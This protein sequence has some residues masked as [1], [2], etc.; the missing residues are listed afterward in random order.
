MAEAALV[1]CG[2]PGRRTFCT[3]ACPDPRAARAAVKP[4]LAYYLWRVAGVVVEQACADP[5]AV[6]EVRRTVHT[7]GVQAAA[8][9]VSDHLVETFAAARRPR[10]GRRAAAAVRHGRPGRRAGLARARPRA[11]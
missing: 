1:R 11:R 9:R 7:Q 2:D 8:A 4:V 10:A 6:A 3:S 5:E